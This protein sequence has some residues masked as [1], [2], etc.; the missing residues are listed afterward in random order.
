MV[1]AIV[2]RTLERI[3]ERSLSHGRSFALSKSPDTLRIFCVIPLTSGRFLYGRVVSQVGKTME[4][5]KGCFSRTAKPK[6]AKSLRIFPI[7][8]EILLPFSET[9]PLLRNLKGS[10]RTSRTLGKGSGRTKITIVSY[11]SFSRFPILLPSRNTVTRSMNGFAPREK[12]IS[13][14]PQSRFPKSP[15]EK[16]PNTCVISPYF[17]M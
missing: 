13:F 11:R 12:T 16:T 8:L 15:A 6:L 5:S 9:P 17:G 14:I 10:A 2:V 3:S 4:F 7:S 1:T